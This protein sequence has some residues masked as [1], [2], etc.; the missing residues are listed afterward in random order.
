MANGI[1]FLNVLVTDEFKKQ[2]K[3]ALVKEGK[4]MKEH[5]YKCCEELIKKHKI[6]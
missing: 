1:S 4:N 2:Y 5:L 6:K 3:I